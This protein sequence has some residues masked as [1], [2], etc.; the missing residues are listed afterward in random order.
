MVERACE[1]INGWLHYN[2]L[3]ILLQPFTNLLD[4]FSLRDVR[5]HVLDPCP[6][7]QCIYRDFNEKA[8]GGELPDDMVVK[9]SLRNVQVSMDFFCLLRYCSKVL[10]SKCFV[11][12]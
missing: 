11:Y 12:S 7:P 5:L 8:F 1:C 3:C 2:I 9:I 6:C 4:P 10:Y